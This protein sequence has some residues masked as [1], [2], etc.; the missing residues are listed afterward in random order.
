MGLEIKYNTGQT[1]LSEEEKEGL[2]IKVITTQ[3]E[4]DQFE[5]LNIEKAVEWTMRTRLKPDK[6]LTEKFMKDLHKK[7]YGDVWKWAGEFRTSEKNIGIKWPLIG[8]E[9]KKLLDDAN[10]WIENGTYIPEEIAI[11]FKHRL[12]SI[13]CF[14]NGNGRHSRMIADIIMESIFK[15]NVF[16]WHQSNMTKP[17]D[18]RKE[19]ISALKKA[20]NGE[21]TPL[22]EFAKN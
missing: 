14:P 19:Y 17:N 21:I 9:L 6:I 15:E 7:M 5:Q 22:I 1:P 20:D 11:R 16:S 12:V 13:H 3:G 10:Y 18:T 2:K 8:V 4:L